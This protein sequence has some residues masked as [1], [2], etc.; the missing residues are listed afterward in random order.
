MGAGNVARAQARPW[1]WRAPGESLSGAGIDDLGGM[2]L[3][4]RLHIE[5][6]AHEIGVAAR[7]EVAR[8]PRPRLAAL[9][10]QALALPFRQAAIQHGDVLDAH[11]AEGPPYPR[12]AKNSGRVINH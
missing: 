9:E 1:L 8:A 3:E 4:Q 5:H 7:G 10:R 2:V 12:R 11:D 6:V